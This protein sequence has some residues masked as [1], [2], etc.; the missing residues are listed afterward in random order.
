MKA[1]WSL[2]LVLLSAVLACKAGTSAEDARG[3]CQAIGVCHGTSGTVA[4]ECHELAHQAD[5]MACAERRT[6]CLAACP[7]KALD[8]SVSLDASS[9][10]DATIDGTSDAAPTAECRA[11]CSCM[12]TTCKSQPKYPFVDETACLATCG[13][14]SAS[15]RRCF[16]SFCVAAKDG[17]AHDCEHATGKFGL[18][19]CAP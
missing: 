10:L 6:E 16:A 15:E 8:A 19:E 18:G 5:D 7:P 1:T 13:S 4:A 17:G 11:Y 2:P 14:F 3:A 12:D 9:S